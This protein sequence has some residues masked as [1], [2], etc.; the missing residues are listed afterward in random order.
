MDRSQDAQPVAQR[1]RQR[2][3]RPASRPAR[4][5]LLPHARQKAGQQKHSLPF[6][7]AASPRDRDP[8]CKG[9]RRSL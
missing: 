7:R 3:R 6:V 5:A 2:V 1:E 9:Q 8:Y 4:L